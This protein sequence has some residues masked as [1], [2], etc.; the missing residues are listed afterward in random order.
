MPVTMPTAM[1]RKYYVVTIRGERGPVDRAE[2]KD[3]VR[4]GDARLTDQVRT[5]TGR[6]LGTVA[7]ALAQV[8]VKDSVDSE[9]ALA[10]VT[11]APASQRMSSRRKVRHGN[12]A[13]KLRLAVTILSLIAVIAVAGV[14]WAVSQNSQPAVIAAPAPAQPGPPTV[15]AAAPPPAAPVAQAAPSPT[16]AP[17]AAAP[18]AQVPADAATNA[19]AD[20]T[21]DKDAPPLP[22]FGTPTDP[23][24]RPSL[25][26]P[27]DTAPAVTAQTP[28]APPP[29]APAPKP[30]SDVVM[31]W[32][33]DAL[34]GGHGWVWP[35]TPPNRIESQSMV[36]HTGRNA[37]R[38]HAEGDRSI[39]A[40]WQWNTA[41]TAGVDFPRL[42]AL[43]VSMKIE[44]RALPSSTQLV[45]Q[46]DD[47]H[48]KYVDLSTLCPALLDG[49]WHDIVVPFADLEEPDFDF[50]NA[51]RLQIETRADGALAFDMYIDDIGYSKV[52][53]DHP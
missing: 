44:G 20:P 14:A 15:L 5:A 2:L 19:A 24:Q 16:A 38:F 34:V 4:D 31:V 28:P 51:N 3:L 50:A 13:Q 21:A 7:E 26:S 27:A 52:D 22:V 8:R 37:L 1:P 40:G 42:H 45:I 25:V 39:N 17:A 23:A 36:V 53:P 35:L 29:S 11:G 41:T 47:T 48:S 12:D 9:L 33:G 10:P 49:N 43:V 6:T 30:A 46:G 32:D 18:I